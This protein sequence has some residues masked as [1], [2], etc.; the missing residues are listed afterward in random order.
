MAGNFTVLGLSDLF[1]GTLWLGLLVW[2]QFVWY[3]GEPLLVHLGVE[4]SC[5]WLCLAVWVTPCCGALWV[6]MFLCFSGG[7]VVRFSWWVGV[8]W[9][10]EYRPFGDFALF[11]GLEGLVRYG[12]FVWCPAFV[13]LQGWFSRFFGLDTLHGTDRWRRCEDAGEFFWVWA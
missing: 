10:I 7:W 12:R 13:L 3:L 2:R 9:S 4:S 11:Y 1:D 8:V 5:I 6:W